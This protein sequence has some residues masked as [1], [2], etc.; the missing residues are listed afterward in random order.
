MT[1]TT[2]VLAAAFVAAFLLRALHL[3]NGLSHDE[4]YTL[5]AFAA[6]PYSRIATTYS[7]PNNHIFHTM[8]VRLATTAL[9]KD[10]WA[11]R[12]PALLAGIAAV[13]VAYLLA[14]GLLA[15]TTAGL[16]AAWLV[17]LHPLHLW[18]SQV[19]RGYSLLILCSLL[20]LYLLHRA[21]TGG[22]AWTWAA[23]AGS[24]FLAAWTLPSGAFHL[25]ALGGWG[26]GVADRPQ[27]RRLA[28]SCG[29]ALG[30][31]GLVYLPLFDQV[32]DAGRRWGIGV[33]DDPLALPEVFADLVGQWIR[34][35]WGLLPGLAALGG[36]VWMV[37]RRH[38]LAGYIGLAWAVPLAAALVMGTAGQPRSYHY[39]FPTF[40]LAAVYGLG[41]APKRW[42]TL[43]AAVALA[44]YGGA[45]VEMARRPVTDPY[46][47][48]AH[49]LANSTQ[50]GDVL[51]LPFIMDVQVWAYG[52]ET[53]A[54]RLIDA[55][56]AQS[57][58]RLLFVASADDGRFGLSNYLMKTDAGSRSVALPPA[59]FERI[60]G[61]GPLEVF[62][63][64]GSGQRLFPPPEL[65]WSVLPASAGGQIRLQAEGRAL[66]PLSGMRLD[67]A[68]GG[69][70]HL[71]STE[72]FAVPGPGLVLLILAKS[73]Q[74]S[75]AS[76]YTRDAQ[77]RLQRPPMLRTMTWPVPVS[78]ADGGQW[79]LEAYILPVR[80]Q[81][82]YGLYLIGA[83][84][85]Q[86][87]ADIACFF[88][89][90][91]QVARSQ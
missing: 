39:L 85:Q 13:P 65:T 47:D 30:L 55:L 73:A 83:G 61:K 1:K 15:S 72:G 57:A 71:Y 28:L 44:A 66:G 74:A 53:I 91:P 26:W 11:V 75:Y 34:W 18:Y 79:F 80:P 12:V 19:A 42:Q 36:L 88:F 33:W 2:F 76:L 46:A 6:Q 24:G 77:G 62:A 63:L 9:G 87:F 58:Q 69:P 89:P 7:A 31:V 49:H 10:N 40:V 56:T 81:Q 21:L 90:L 5:E 25:V 60:Y 27:R 23:F 20:S 41:L 16:V 4:A 51:V 70:I 14:R 8:L 32:A 78:L 45:A 68:T 22:R 86:H 54:Q 59:A 3:D 52:K 48:L 17:A 50:K 37:R 82:P 35:P 64:Q 67:N 38:P 84:A 29:V 43:T